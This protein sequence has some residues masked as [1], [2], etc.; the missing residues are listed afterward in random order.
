MTVARMMGVERKA[1]RRKDPLD[2]E[3]TPPDPVLSLIEAERARL[4]RMNLIWE[5]AVGQ[6]HI[7]NILAGREFPVVGS[8][9]V[10]RGYPGT[11]VKSFLDFQEPL[12]DGVITNPPFGRGLPARFVLHCLK[13]KIPYCALLLKGTYLHQK[14]ALNLFGRWRP[15]RYHH[16][17]YRVDFTGEGRSPWQMTWY[18]W[19][20]YATATEVHVLP[21][22][23]GGRGEREPDLFGGSS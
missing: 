8:D 18:V 11:V 7:A 15:A 19:D 23:E 13:L 6:G 12:G 2:F 9:I 10:D 16:L 5:P 21:R 3:P 1:A 14:R 22:P 20:A 17:S 4:E